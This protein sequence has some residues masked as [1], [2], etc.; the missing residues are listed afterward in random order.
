MT[1]R[2]PLHIFLEFA[3]GAHPASGVLRSPGRPG[4]AFVGWTELF[5]ALEATLRAIETERRT[6]G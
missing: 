1:A 4:R 6:A 3:A 5:A 2:E